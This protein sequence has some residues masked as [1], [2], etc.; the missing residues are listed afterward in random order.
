MVSLPLSTGVAV[1]L[2]ALFMLD[3]SVRYPCCVGGRSVLGV[4]AKTESYF[5]YKERKPCASQHNWSHHE[6]IIYSLLF[7][8]NPYHSYVRNSGVLLRTPFIW[9][10]LELWN[11]NINK[12][13]RKHYHW[14]VANIV[15]WNHI[16]GMKFVKIQFVLITAPVIGFQ[17]N[18]TFIWWSHD[19]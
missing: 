15:E 16:N 3:T 7:N 1:M 4:M 9:F 12:Q 8:M 17:G 11:T 14:H 19:M 13:N 18:E 5:P 6:F 10:T 2:H